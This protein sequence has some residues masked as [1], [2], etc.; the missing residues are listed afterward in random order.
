MY[1]CII[2]YKKGSIS[3][4]EK[5]KYLVLMKHYI[6]TK[7]NDLLK[8]YVICLRG[9]VFFLP[10]APEHYALIPLRILYKLHKCHLSSLI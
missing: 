1:R 5:Y 6:S 10:F 2:E 3:K 9:G 8:W 4:N 7:K